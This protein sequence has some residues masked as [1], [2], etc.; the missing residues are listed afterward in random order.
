[1]FVSGACTLGQTIEPALMPI[2]ATNLADDATVVTKETDSSDVEELMDVSISTVAQQLS[3]CNEEQ[4]YSRCGVVHEE[5]SPA[6]SVPSGP[7]VDI[8]SHR[9]RPLSSGIFDLS[10]N[11]S[12]QNSTVHVNEHDV[13]DGVDDDDEQETDDTDADDHWAASGASDAVFVNS[14]SVACPWDI[15]ME[16][17]PIPQPTPDSMLTSGDYMLAQTLSAA[18]EDS[19]SASEVH[20]DYSLA[21]NSNEQTLAD[22]SQSPESDVGYCAAQYFSKYS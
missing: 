18:D 1:M 4:N 10:N 2:V 12:R 13:N 11:E 16:T 5:A 14:Y 7:P 6:I 9:E 19:F 20:I 3:S 22:G 8:S 21:E 15:S 17:S